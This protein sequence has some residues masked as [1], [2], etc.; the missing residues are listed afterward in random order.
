MPPKSGIEARSFAA[1]AD[2]PGA[3]AKMTEIAA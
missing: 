2:E 1:G 3:D